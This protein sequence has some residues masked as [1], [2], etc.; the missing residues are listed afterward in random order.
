MIAAGLEGTVE[1]TRPDLLKPFKEARRKKKEARR[2]EREGRV[3]L[4]KVTKRIEDLDEMDRVH[5]SLLGQ[6]DNISR[7]ERGNFDRG[8]SGVG[9]AILA[10]QAEA[11]TQL[12]E[13]KGKIAA[14]IERRKEIRAGDVLGEL[15]QELEN[16]GVHREA[17]KQLAEVQAAVKFLKQV[18][19]EMPFYHAARVE[20]ARRVIEQ[21]AVE[22]PLREGVMQQGEVLRQVQE[23]IDKKEISLARRMDEIVG[24]DV[25]VGKEGNFTATVDGQQDRRNLQIARSSEQLVENLRSDLEREGNSPEA[26]TAA[27][28]KV[29]V[30]IEKPGLTKKPLSNEFLTEEG[31][32]SYEAEHEDELVDPLRRWAF[33]HVGRQSVEEALGCRIMVTGEGEERQIDM[34][35][36]PEEEEGEERSELFA[37]LV[38]CEEVERQIRSQL[39]EVNPEDVNRVQTL[40][41]SLE[42]ND[43]LRTALLGNVDARI[44]G[45][46]VA[47]G[48]RSG[49]LKS[50][51]AETG[52]RGAE[53]VVACGIV[54][55]VANYVGVR[56]RRLEAQAILEAPEKSTALWRSIDQLT[57]TLGV[58]VNQLQN[59]VAEHAAQYGE[60]MA[61]QLGDKS[62]LLVEA[63]KQAAH[64]DK[65]KELGPERADELMQQ[66]QVIKKLAAAGGILAGALSFTDQFRGAVSRLSGRR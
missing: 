23:A 22:L 27:A 62:A 17:S 9:Q 49:K 31:L 16:R 14:A 11:D 19:E 12:K 51:L 59:Y 15:G 61:T 6:G 37:K 33:K 57:S 13:A 7:P 47:D 24:S 1:T 48:V 4:A 55:G 39:Q 25:F 21:A 10:S 20:A 35:L 50:S 58:D 54:L 26:V 52:V 29:R 64:L 32:S 34:E 28:D 43:E 40:V 56:P 53:A 3:E 44:N 42:A 46:L 30:L 8:I 5:W 18:E 65:L 63:L 36:V 45:L 60:V 38:E 66:A 2:D 41:K